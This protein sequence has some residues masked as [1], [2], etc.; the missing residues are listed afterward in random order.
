LS[1]PPCCHPRRGS[2][3]AAVVVVASQYQ[4]NQN[5]VGFDVGYTWRRNAELRIGQDEYWYSVSKRV[6]FDNLSIP[7]QQQSVSSLRYTYYGTDNAVLPFRGVNT[8]L[9]V[10]RHEPS[11]GN[12]PFTL[13]EARVAGYLPLSEKNSVFSPPAEAPHSAH[14]Q[15]SPTSRASRSEDP[16]ASV[17]TAGMSS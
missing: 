10:E 8:F 6:D 11:K 15:M 2:A 1:S 3:V 9:R 7:P 13:A 5:G 12:D 4:I 17:P 16:S 14:R